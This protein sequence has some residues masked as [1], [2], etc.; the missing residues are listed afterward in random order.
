MFEFKAFVTQFVG[1]SASLRLQEWFFVR[2]VP[3]NQHRIK[4]YEELVL[5][6]VRC[7]LINDNEVGYY[8]HQVTCVALGAEVILE[9]GAIL[10]R[11]GTSMVALIAHHARKPVYVF[12]ESY[13]FLRKIYLTQRDIPQRFREDK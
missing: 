3:L 11:A 7:Q 6:G 9:N 5:D 13:K 10:N 8:M 2:G 4:L 1:Q 12:A